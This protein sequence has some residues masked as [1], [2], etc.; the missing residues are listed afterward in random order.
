MKLARHI[1]MI[2]G[3]DETK[4]ADP[5]NPYYKEGKKSMVQAKKVQIN[6]EKIYERYTV[7][8]DEKNLKTI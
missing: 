1:Q 2:G 3:S 5:K 6:C 7:F 8:K 4:D